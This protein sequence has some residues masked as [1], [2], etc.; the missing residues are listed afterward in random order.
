[1]SYRCAKCDI[2]LDD[3][4]AYEYRGAFSCEEHFDAV[5]EERDRERQAIIQEESAKTDPIHG[6]DL[7]DNAVGRENRKLLKH[8][9]SRAGK[10]SERLKKYERPTEGDG[11]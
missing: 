3:H 4:E 8:K 10:E 5:I 2:E 9:I 7:S 6:L 11:S 1:M